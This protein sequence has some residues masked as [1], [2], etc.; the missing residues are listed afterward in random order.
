M[1]CQLQFAGTLGIDFPVMENFHAAVGT[2]TLKRRK[3]RPGAFDLHQTGAQFSGT[4]AKFCKKLITGHGAAQLG[5]GKATA[6]NDQF[7]TSDRFFTVRNLK[8]VGT[9]L[10][11]RHFIA[12]FQCDIFFHQSKAQHIHHRIRLVGIGID[13][14]VFLCDRKQAQR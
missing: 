1:F 10:N 4:V 6:G 5:A 2:D 14:A 9:F 13:F 12:G 3:L 8:T 7:M 11:L